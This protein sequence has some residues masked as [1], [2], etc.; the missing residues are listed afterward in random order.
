MVEGNIKLYFYMFYDFI[1]RFNRAAQIYVIYKLYL[2]IN[3]THRIG[4]M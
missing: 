2:K 4:I 3:L 1:V